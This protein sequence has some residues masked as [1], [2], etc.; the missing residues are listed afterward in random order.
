[1]NSNTIEN[2]LINQFNHLNSVSDIKLSYQYDNF[3]KRAIGWKTWTLDAYY[4]GSCLVHVWESESDNGTKYIK[5]LNQ[6]YEKNFKTTHNLIYTVR[7]HP[8]GFIKE[9]LEDNLS[10]SQ[11]KYYFLEYCK[12]AYLY[13]EGKKLNFTEQ[14]LIDIKNMSN[15][16][17]ELFCLRVGIT[18]EYLNKKLN[19][20]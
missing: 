1:M 14:N 8:D 3:A 15:E 12:M 20:F 19:L 16:V 17:K 9:S 11:K 5:F 6:I 13:V 10:N 7:N 4:N 2:N 18:L